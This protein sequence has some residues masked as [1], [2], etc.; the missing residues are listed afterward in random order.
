M[1]TSRFNFNEEVGRYTLDD[2]WLAIYRHRWIVL[3]VIVASAVLAGVI[4]LLITP[5]YEAVAAFYVPQ[6]VAMPQFA[7]GPSQLR[8]PNPVLGQAESYAALL[9]GWDAARQI[10]AEFP[11]KT[12]DDLQRDADFVSSRQGVITVYVRD[13]D[14]ARAAAIANRYV[15]YFEEFH[16]RLSQGQ[17]EQNLANLDAK[18]SKLA[19]QKAEHEKQIQT[20]EEQHRIASLRVELVELEEKRRDFQDQLQTARVQQ[21]V[22]RRRVASL[23]ERLAEE[24][25]AYESGQVVIDT[26]VISTLREAMAQAEIDLA[27]QQT[28]RTA[29]HPAVVALRSRYEAAKKNL[30]QEVQRIISSKSKLAGSHYT[31]LREDLT[32]AYVEL[33][34]AEARVSALGSVNDEISER[35]D[36]IPAIMQ[37]YR[38]L[39]ERVERDRGQLA[40]IDE[41]YAA[42]ST[43][44]LRLSEP[45][46]VVQTAQPPA[47]GN[48]VFPIPLLNMFIAALAATVV[49]VLYALLLDHLETS[50]RR[51]KLRQ[52]EMDVWI[53]EMTR[54]STGGRLRHTVVAA[55]GNGNGNG[56]GSVI[57]PL[58]GE[59]GDN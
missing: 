46:V 28:E 45:V 11:G 35:I 21:E 26:R 1:S 47:P 7:V 34:A 6:D 48:P 58:H 14:P 3:V 8:S 53:T 36:A 44:L 38:R 32:T 2:Y 24:A 40:A 33:A 15:S 9:K 57:D 12:P 23:E 29:D 31:Q 42:A 39:E 49:G 55:N 30:E 25:E 27:E 13:T 20:F 52:M 22:G 50:R 19:E 10:A 37:Q 56:N 41:A 16:G 17:L 51:R 54:R 43:D 18:R 4:S 59:L 5:R